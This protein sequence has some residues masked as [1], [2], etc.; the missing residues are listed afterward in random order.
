MKQMNSVRWYRVFISLCI[1]LSVGMSPAVFY[2]PSGARKEIKEYI[3]RW[4]ILLAFTETIIRSFFAS[5]SLRNTFLQWSQWQ[6]FQ[7]GIG[8]VTFV[9]IIYASKFTTTEF[10]LHI[11]LHFSGIL[12]WEGVLEFIKFLCCD[13][14]IFEKL[15]GWFVA[16]IHKLGANK[17]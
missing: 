12:F 14:K 3:N 8:V 9:V 1:L 5:K 17:N 7:V 4:N 6:R 2:S 15:C 11:F 16:P 13:R 10:A